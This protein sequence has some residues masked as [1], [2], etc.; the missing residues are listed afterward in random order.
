MTELLLN[1][2]MGREYQRAV[3]ALF[4]GCLSRFLQG[5]RRATKILSDAIQSLIRDVS[6]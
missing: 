1:S 3:M 2:E 4:D 6:P 5:P